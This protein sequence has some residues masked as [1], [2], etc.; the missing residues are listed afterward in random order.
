VDREERPDVDAVYMSATQAMT[1]QGGWPMTVFATPDGAPLY[2][3]TYFPKPQFT[4]LVQAVARAWAGDRDRLISDSERTV[5]ALAEQANSLAG[6]GTT[7]LSVG[8]LQAATALAVTGL[9]S[10]YDSADGGFGHAPKFPPS[11]SLEFLLRHYQRTG[12]D[13]VSGQAAL[14]MAAGTCAAMA[15]GGMYDQLGG[16]FARYSVD[17]TWTVPHF[18]KML[19][20][21][22]LLAG[23]Y[24]HWWRL[25]G[26]ELARRIAEETCDFMVRELRTPEGGFAA[27]LDADSDDGSGH[28]E[29]G[30]FYVWTPAQLREVLGPDDGDFAIAAFGVTERGTFEH[31]TSVLQRRHSVADTERLDRIRGTLLVAREGRSRPGRDDKVV[32]AWNGLA[33]G[34]LAEA[35]ILFNRPDLVTAA[36]QAAQLLV[37]VHLVSSGSLPSSITSSSPDT[38]S[39]SV[40]IAPPSSPAA[41]LVRTSRDGV[42]GTSAGQLEDYACVA[43]G[44]LTLF[45]VTGKARWATVAG[46]LLETLLAQFPDSSGGFFDAPAD[47]EQLIYRPADPLD[48]ATPSGTFA[49]AGALASLAALT[50][51]VQYREAAT[52]ALGV[53]P[54]VAGRYPRAAGKGLA[55][56]EALL[57]GPVEVAIVGPADDPRTGDLLRAALH[58]APGGAVL[59]LGDPGL[60]DTVAETV[61]LLA[62]RTL[63]SGAPAAYVCQGFACQLPVTTPAGVREQLSVTMNGG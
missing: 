35:G 13:S 11:M 58:A 10:G 21:N 23:V 25:A 4:R 15:S 22:A 61:P 41:R 17:G 48:G 63:V 59:A 18:E 8:E 51:S 14:R 19:Y 60:G 27:S 31:G 55:V 42:A 57:S 20:D 47:G 62:G 5:A 38:P 49:A 28:A 34:A 32:A 46:E 26:T 24:T 39:S 6:I 54:A 12:P 53:V 3:G 33:I 7:A 40:G 2:C 29:E 45:G 1:G 36:S 43:A 37:D 52:A 9:E 30:A 16:G 44:L 56:A 50:G